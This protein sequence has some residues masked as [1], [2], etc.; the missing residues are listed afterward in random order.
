MPDMIKRGTPVEFTH[1]N[2]VRFGICA[3]T[4]ILGTEIEIETTT[5]IVKSWRILSYGWAGWL[6]EELIKIWEK[7]NPTSQEEV[8][9]FE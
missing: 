1:E 9:E 5:G 4:G 6:P 8:Y 7:H 3:K 2:K